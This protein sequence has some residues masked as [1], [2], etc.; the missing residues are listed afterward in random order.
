[1]VGIKVIL[2]GIQFHPNEI[3]LKITAFYLHVGYKRLIYE[4][5]RF[6][7][8]QTLFYELNINLKKAKWN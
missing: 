4:I 8:Y 1:M 5:F 2:R 7:I 3:R 6:E